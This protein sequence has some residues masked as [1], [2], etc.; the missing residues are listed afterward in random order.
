MAIRT[1]PTECSG[2]L[3][4]FWENRV[5]KA[6]CHKVRSDEIAR[7]EILSAPRG[8]QSFKDSVGVDLDDII[9]SCGLS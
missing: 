4:K 7:Y 8:L 5:F 6:S 1:Q 3:K 9:D 2:E